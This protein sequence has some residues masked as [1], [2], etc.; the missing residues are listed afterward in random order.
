MNA[1]RKWFDDHW[2][3]YRLYHIPFWIGYALIWYGFSLS[4]SG[5]SPEWDQLPL[6]LVYLICYLGVTYPNL[7]WLMP[8]YLPQKRYL[9]YILL[10]IGIVLF[11]STV[12]ALWYLLVQIGDWSSLCGYTGLIW[13]LQK[14]SRRSKGTRC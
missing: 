10:N 11:F 1:I 5:H 7:Y 14:K 9:I 13:W 8:R 4:V 2:Q 12:I 6:N 3:R